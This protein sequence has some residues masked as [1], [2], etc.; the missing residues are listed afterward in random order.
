MILIAN[1]IADD[2][3]EI[4]CNWRDSNIMGKGW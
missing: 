2:D 1:A 3:I 4:A